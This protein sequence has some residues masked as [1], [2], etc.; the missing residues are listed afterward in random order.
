MTQSDDQ[1]YPGIYPREETK[2]VGF[3]V[4]DAQIPKDI[5]EHSASNE[6]DMLPKRVVWEVFDQEITVDDLI[7]LQLVFTKSGKVYVANT[8]AE[9]VPPETVEQLV[10]TG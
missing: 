10:P 3:F 2:K 6:I 7:N 5:E 4:A 8:I 1:R 9:N